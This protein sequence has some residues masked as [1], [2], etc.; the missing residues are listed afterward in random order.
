MIIACRGQQPRALSRRVLSPYRFTTTLHWSNAK[1]QHASKPPSPQSTTQESHPAAAVT[2]VTKRAGD[3]P[4]QLSK[5]FC[6]GSFAGILGSLAGMGGGFVMIPLMTSSL[7]KLSQHQAHGTSLFAVAATGVA[8]ALGYSG[9]VDLEAAVA[10]SVS[11]MIM[12]RA[13]AG[14][15]S[16]MSER[17]LKRA[18]GVFMLLVAPLVPAKAYFM[19]V[20]DETKKKSITATTNRSALVGKGF[21]KRIGPPAVIGLGSGFLAGLFGV[22][23]GAIVVP[24]LTL[25]TD[26]TH[27][28]AL[29]TSLC[30]M[31][32][33]AMVGTSTH[34][35]KGNV[36]MKIAP[37]LAVGS[38]VGAYLGG[39]LGLRTD[40][41]TLRWGFSS[42]MLAL[43]IRTL[44]K[45]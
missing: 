21:L 20:Q 19:H 13:G 1:R 8:G 12:A 38:F 39:K 11:G 33:P 7:L 41:T 6:V 14:M 17:S 23:G 2:T 31:A 16:T 4:Y 15:T 25:C 37:T 22:G 34:F 18:L 3:V 35:S 30:A 43:G 9:Q 32:L 10:I 44:V 26:M 45:A 27:Y 36:A 5:A 29:G 28:Q 42:L 40:E 24:A